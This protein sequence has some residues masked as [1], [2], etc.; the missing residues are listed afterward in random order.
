MRDAS[1]NR[2]VSIILCNLA[3]R[4]SATVLAVLVAGLGILAAQ[5]QERTLVIAATTSF[6]DSGLFDFLQPKFKERTGL[7]LRLV[8]RSTAQALNAAR[9]GFIDVVIGNSPAALDRFMDAGDGVRR[10]NL[11]FDDFV[12]VGPATDPAGLMGSKNAAEA[13]R[14]LA[15]MRIPFVSRGDSSGTHALEQRLWQA[16]GVNPKA[17]SGN[18]YLE[19][20]LGMG[21]TLALADRLGAYVLTDRASWLARSEQAGREILVEGDPALFNQYEII[22]INPAKYRNVDAQSATA[23][24]DWIVSDEGQSLIASFRLNDR[25]AFYP[26]AKGQN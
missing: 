23:F 20:G 21:L 12:I 8:S 13:L 16:A 6:Q 4:R 22:A 24:V 15:F 9:N 3:M 19:S 17:R 5:A 7:T 11:M 25:Q 14:K 18:W 10:Q 2:L 26:N 1:D